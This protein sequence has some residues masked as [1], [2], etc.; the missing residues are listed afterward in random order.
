MSTLLK[1]FA[2]NRNTESRVQPTTKLV[3]KTLLS[4]REQ[5]SKNLTIAGKIQ[6]KSYEEKF[7][8]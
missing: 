4:L 1:S 5:W 6:V 8:N 7:V 3:H 2:P